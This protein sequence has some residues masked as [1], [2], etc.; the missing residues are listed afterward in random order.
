MEK[1]IKKLTL[2]ERV[3]TSNLNI[4][5]E[6]YDY[7]CT[8]EDCVVETIV[9]EDYY[10]YRQE[11]DL[12]NKEEWITFDDC[13]DI[14]IKVVDNVLHAILSAYDKIQS[15]YDDR[16]RYTRKWGI[17]ITLPKE[18]ITKFESLIDIKFD[19]FCEKAYN[20]HLEYMRLQWIKNFKKDILGE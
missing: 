9:N 14:E 6:I 20:D 10:L 3:N 11:F 7:V 4:W 8:N 18:F 19:G 12:T 17:S 13:R 5:W 1:L 15:Y 16:E 2:V